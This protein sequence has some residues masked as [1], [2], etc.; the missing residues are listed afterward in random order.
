MRGQD[1]SVLVRERRSFRDRAKDLDVGIEV[2]D[3]LASLE[4]MAEEPGLDGRGELD[5]VVDRGHAPELGLVEVEVLGQEDF[6]GLW[7]MWA[8]A[9]DDERAEGRARV[10]R[11]KGLGEY[12]RLRR[13]VAGDDCAGL[14]GH[15]PGASGRRPNGCSYESLTN[16][17]SP[18]VTC[19]FSMQRLGLS[20]G[21]AATSWESNPDETHQS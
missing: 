14:H 15:W 10:V 9:V 4:Q 13:V 16:S 11:R 20:G 19:K 8:W 3:R 1:D 7:R 18:A 6:V 5:H 12:T 17:G 2:D 21:H